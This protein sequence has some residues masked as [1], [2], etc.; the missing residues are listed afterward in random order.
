MAANWMRRTALVA[1]CASA[2]LL[3]ACGSSTT[4]SAITPDRFIAFGDAYSDIGQKGSRYTVNNDTV[5][6]WTLQLASH[7]Q[8]TLAPVSAGGLSYAQGNAR[9]AAQPDAAGDATTPTI[10]AQIDRFLASQTF[11]PNDI[12]LLNGG[13]SDLIVGMAAVRAGTLSAADYVAQARQ[14]GKDLA[15]QILRLVNAGAPHVVVSGSYDLGKTPWAIA[16]GQETLLSEAS[17]R[18]NEAL[19]VAINDLGAHVLYIDSAYYVN[20]YTSAPSSFSFSYPKTA[21]CTSVDAGNG[22]G[23]GTGQV[24]S[25]LCTPSTLLAGADVNLYVFADN[26]Y[27]S[28][29]AHRQLG[30]YAYDKLRARW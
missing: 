24:N 17:S 10:T 21:V 30:T 9:I 1:A 12:V 27:L 8:K 19:L 5:N 26:V 23:T 4:E 11:A 29:S 16:I 22:I 13:I 6:N 14:N 3:A 15:A 7:Y 20:L 28:P 18:F 25:A 2:L